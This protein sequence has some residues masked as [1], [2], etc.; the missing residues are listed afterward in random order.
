MKFCTQCGSQLTDDAKFC[1]GCG[2]PC[3][4]VVPQITPTTQAPHKKGMAWDHLQKYGH[5]KERIS[6]AVG[7]HTCAVLYDGTVV[8]TGCN[9][10]GQCEVKTWKNVR[11]VVGT[12]TATFGLTREGGIL[13]S[14]AFPA[15]G[16]DEELI[17]SIA[18]PWITSWPKNLQ[19]ISASKGK[20]EHVLGLTMD[21]RVYACGTNLY[22]E[23][24]VETWNNITEIKAARGISLGLRKDGT[25]VA[26][27]NTKIQN[28][29]SE[30]NGVEHIYSNETGDLVAGLRHDGTVVCFSTDVRS[31]QM[32][33]SCWRDIIDISCGDKAVAGIQG[34]GKCLFAGTIPETFKENGMTDIL[35]INIAFD[36]IVA[37]TFKGTT[38]IGSFENGV[39]EV[40]ANRLVMSTASIWGPIM[41]YEDGHVQVAIAYDDVPRFGQD[42]TIGWKMLRPQEKSV[43]HGSCDSQS[44]HS[45]KA[46]L[47]KK[48]NKNLVWGIVFLFIFWPVSIYFF[49]KYSEANKELMTPVAKGT[50]ERPVAVQQNVCKEYRMRCNV[51]GKVYCYSDEDL[52]RNKQA[53]TGA[54]LSSGMALVEGL[55]GSR[56]GSISMNSYNATAD[57]F[58]SQITDY[59]K[60]PQC[61][62]KDVTIIGEEEYVL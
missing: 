28:V 42:E 57:R 18:G 37:A 54:I 62:S 49:C 31:I 29:V 44:Y 6:G 19:T 53:R 56:L 30:W 32:E 17:S 47:E 40:A 43:I 13:F 8:A 16:D 22:G 4:S 3:A 26:S 25:V 39:T 10:A 24:N 5:L 55:D 38:L 48:K 50:S 7:A 9:D 21:G 15:V 59:T 11:A 27:G 51:C 20:G 23:C 61:N 2:T 36:G 34:N 58:A 12:M 46:D 41:I 1:T 60:C 52:K 35:T 14:G 33:V 45:R